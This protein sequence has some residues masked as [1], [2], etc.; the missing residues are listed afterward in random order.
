MDYNIYIGGQK[1]LAVIFCHFKK[2]VI[3]TLLSLTHYDYRLDY[4]RIFLGGKFQNSKL[5]CHFLLDR[6]FTYVP[7][8]NYFVSRILHIFFQTYFRITLYA[9]CPKIR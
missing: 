5:F 3:H 6:T 9:G 1:I 7:T 2:N 4:D 8:Q